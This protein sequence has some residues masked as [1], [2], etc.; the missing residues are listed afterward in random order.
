MKEFRLIET[1]HAAYAVSINERETVYI[2]R[3]TKTSASKRRNARNR[4]GYDEMKSASFT[5]P[6]VFNDNA[7]AIAAAAMLKYRLGF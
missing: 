2:I 7:D 5:L 3:V 6:K 4:G 1:R